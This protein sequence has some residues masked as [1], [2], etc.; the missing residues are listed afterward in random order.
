VK[1]GVDERQ[2]GVNRDRRDT[3]IHEAA[4]VSSEGWRAAPTVQQ[5]KKGKQAE[6]RSRKHTHSVYIRF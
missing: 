1:S 4:L 5:E 3:R 6:K 2:A